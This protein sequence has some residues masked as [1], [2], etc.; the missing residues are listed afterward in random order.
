MLTKSDFQNLPGYK[1]I[2]D[3]GEQVF[4]IPNWGKGNNPIHAIVAATWPR[5]PDHILVWTAEGEVEVDVAYCRPG[6]AEVVVAWIDALKAD[7][8]LQ[9]ACALPFLTT[10]DYEVT[11]I[12]EHPTTAL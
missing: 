1:A 9:G 4:C 10:P 5:D 6:N 8:E 11:V 7:G 2:Y 12:C 3:H